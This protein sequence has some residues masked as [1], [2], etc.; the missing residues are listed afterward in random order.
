MCV[1]VNEEGQEFGAYMFRR[2]VPSMHLA[3]PDVRWMVGV[4]YSNSDLLYL[5]IGLFWVI[6]LVKMYFNYLE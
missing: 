5:Y 2:T 1:K 4:F 6:S 3:P